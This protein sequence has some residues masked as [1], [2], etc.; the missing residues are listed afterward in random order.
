MTLGDRVSERLRAMN[1]SQAELARRS[2]L[3]QQ[4][5]NALIKRNKVGTVHLHRIAR[6]LMTSPDFLI[7]ETDDPSIDAADAALTSEDREWLDLLHALAPADRKAALQLVR[8]IAHSAAS[9]IASE[10]RE[11]FQR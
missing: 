1:I 7:G 3:A 10:K 11:E 5:V 2:G 4:T 6:E 8:T 9:P